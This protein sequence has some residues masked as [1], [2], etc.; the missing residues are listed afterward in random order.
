M[1]GCFTAKKLGIGRD[2]SPLKMV[3]YSVRRQSLLILMRNASLHIKPN[4]AGALVVMP[5][6]QIPYLVAR[7]VFNASGDHAGEC[8]PLAQ[9]TLA[10]PGVSLIFRE[11]NGNERPLPHGQMLA[12]SPEDGS[13]IIVRT[14][15]P[16]AELDV[17][18]VLESY[19]F[20]RFGRRILKSSGL[21]G[22]GKRPHRTFGNTVPGFHSV[23]LV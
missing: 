20:D 22:S 9:F 23:Q 8:D 11:A 5:A 6:D 14:S 16:S 4:A 7:L 3:R 19:S 12:L 13:E 2:L 17:K 18:G 21:A 15:Q 10:P 1:I